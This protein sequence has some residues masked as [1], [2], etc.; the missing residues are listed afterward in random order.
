MGLVEEAVEGAF[1]A[2][3]ILVGL[4]AVVAA[5]VVFPKA[6]SGLRP[7]AKRIIGGALALSESARG[8]FAETR[9]RFSDLVAEVR[10]ERRGA[11]AAAAGAVKASAR[12][13]PRASEEAKPRA[14]EEAKPTTP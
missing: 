9:E 11:G 13:K 8:T 14:S 1:E 3:G 10:E 12:A 7:I 6:A 4:G 5:P 2:P